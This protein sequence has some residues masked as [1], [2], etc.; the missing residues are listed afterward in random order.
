M[1]DFPIAPSPD[2]STR[3]VEE[4]RLAAAL[5]GLWVLSVVVLLMKKDSPFAQFHARQ[6]ALLFLFSLLLW[7]VLGVFGRSAWVFRDLLKFGTYALMM[8]GFVQAL[9]GKRWVLPLLGP[10]AASLRL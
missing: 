6:G 1:E 9:R 5:G 2:P 10:L 4:N 8:I 7:I 3:D